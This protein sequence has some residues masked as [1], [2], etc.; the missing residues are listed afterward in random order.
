M[1]VKTKKMKVIDSSSLSSSSQSSDMESPDLQ[2]AVVRIAVAQICNSV[3]YDGAQSSA[4]ETLTSVAS[5]Y[6]QSLA[7]AAAISATSTGR[8]QCNL[9]DIIR[10]LEDLHSG[11]GF[12]GNSDL[13]RRLYI[14]S[15]SSI[16]IDT[17]KFVYLT[18]EIPFAKPLPRRRHTLPP[19]PPCFFDESGK[20]NH[21]PRWLPAFP[22]ISDVVEKTV[23]PAPRKDE[24]IELIREISKLPE[25]RKKVSFTIGGDG[26]NVIEMQSGVDLRGGICKGGKRVSCQIYDDENLVNAS[27]SS[28]HDCKFKLSLKNKS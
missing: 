12:H 15:D 23:V 20:L 16:L 25:K 19:N 5:R 2:T 22:E 3:G 9:L 27:C 28:H 26:R 11:G 6:L 21:I 8:T 14:L 24:R 17:M 4:L 1:K 18:D 13:K 7:N 10:A